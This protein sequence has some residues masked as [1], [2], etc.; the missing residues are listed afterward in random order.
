MADVRKGQAPDHL[1][2][3]EFR[4]RFHNSYRDPAFAAESAA[5][6][7]LEAIAWQAYSEGRKAPLTRKAGEGFADPDYELSADDMMP[8][9]R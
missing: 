5:L 1:A 7:R 4:I 6:D 8:E 2:R 9:R 3:S